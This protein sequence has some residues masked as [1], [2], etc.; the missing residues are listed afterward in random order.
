MDYADYLRFVLALLLVLG[1]IGLLAYAA[2]RWGFGMGGRSGRR[3]AGG[4]R[5]LAVV[6]VLTL[7]TRRRLILV[8]RD[9][10]EH[11]ILT[12]ATQ[13]LVVE[14]GIVPD[15]DRRAGF[16]RALDAAGAPRPA[17]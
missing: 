9:G 16:A 6:E 1:L 17:E 13:D 12:G 15:A 4:R 7:D 8:E 3:N 2:R 14:R 10:V 11:L 5:R